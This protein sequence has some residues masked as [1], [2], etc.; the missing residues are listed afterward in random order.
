MEILI[1]FTNK[2][3]NKNLKKKKNFKK[4]KKKKKKI[5]IKILEIHNIIINI[6][7]IEIFLLF[8]DV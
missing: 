2:I 6:Y 4:K 5:K 8:I 1:K 7:N 3:K